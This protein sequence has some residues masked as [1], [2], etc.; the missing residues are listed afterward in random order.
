MGSPAGWPRI[1]RAANGRTGPELTQQGSEPFHRTCLGVIARRGAED[2]L[3][4]RAQLRPRFRFVGDAAQREGL[5]A[6][7][8]AQQAPHGEAG[9]DY[10]RTETGLFRG[11]ADLR[12]GKPERSEE[13]DRRL[14]LVEERLG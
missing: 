9:F 3:H 13:G 2:L 10:A 11:A 4:A 5:T 12:Q 8:A 14:R 1:S 6:Q 7:L